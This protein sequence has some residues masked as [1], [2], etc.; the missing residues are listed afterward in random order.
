MIRYQNLSPLFI[1]VF[2]SACATP[3]SSVKT[4]FYLLSAPDLIDQPQPLDDTETVMVGPISFADY[5][6]RSSVVRRESTNR[7]EISGVQQWAGNLEKEFQIALLKNLSVLDQHRFYIRFP[8]MLKMVP[9]YRL[10][11]DVLR[12][13]V[14]GGG[15]ARM[16]V[17]WAWLNREDISIARGR[18]AHSVAAGPTHEEGVS[19]LSQ[20]LQEFAVEIHRALPGASMVSEP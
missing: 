3:G 13:D 1:I 14:Q 6:K 7:Y 2:I 11:A 19:S 15:P 8:S 17:I 12:F 4:D 10:R 18:F 16:E 20:L 5:L 9:Q